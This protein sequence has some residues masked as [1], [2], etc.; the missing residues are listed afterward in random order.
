[1]PKA[2][3]STL[4]IGAKQLVVQEALDTILCCSLSYAPSLTPSTIVKSTLLAGAEM[5]T[6]LAPPWRC[7]AALSPSVKMPVDSTTRSTPISDQGILAGS[8]SE[9]TLMLRPSIRRSPLSASTC[10]G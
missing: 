10:P 8:R 4:T 5:M 7:P 3:C 9:K 1:M 6:L 2:S